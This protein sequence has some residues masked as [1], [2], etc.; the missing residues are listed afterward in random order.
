MRQGPDGADEGDE[1]SPDVP[2]KAILCHV[3]DESIQSLEIEERVFNMHPVHITSS[4][5]HER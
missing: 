5:P 3:R 2:F 4:Q 1:A